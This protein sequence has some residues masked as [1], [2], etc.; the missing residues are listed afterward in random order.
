M[1]E[2]LATKAL[3]RLGS[4]SSL[5]FSRDG[6]L[7]ELLTISRSGQVRHKGEIGKIK[8]LINTD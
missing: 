7:V 3:L 6:E 2:I 8:P 5:D 1:K 4:T